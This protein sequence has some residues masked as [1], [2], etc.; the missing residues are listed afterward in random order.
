MAGL[1]LLLSACDDTSSPTAPS[2]DSLQITAARSVLRAGETQPLAVTNSAGVP[3]TTASWTTTDSSV[4]TVSA[5]G[6][7]NA[8]RAGSATVTATSGSSSG[9]LALRVVPDYTGTWTGGATRVQLTCSAASTTP[10]C[11][12][13]ASTSASISLRVV[14]VGDQLTGTLIDSAEPSVGVP[15]TGQVAPDDQLAMSGRIDSP[16]VAPTL[17]VEIA[18]LRGSIDVALATMSGNYQLNVDR[19]RA[20]GGALQS[21]YRTQVQFRDLR[22]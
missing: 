2:T 7:A 16:L 20:T 18:T 19:V 9:S 4:L 13:G 17:R 12:P 8:G 14:Q 5:A 21:D 3:V 10:V 6:I 1:A 15:L 22:R 11:A